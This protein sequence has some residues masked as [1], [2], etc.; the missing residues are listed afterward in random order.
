LNGI[1]GGFLELESLSFW[2]DTIPL[3]KNN[4]AR[5]A[6]AAQFPRSIRRSIKRG[7]CRSVRRIIRAA[8]GES[9]AQ[10]PGNC[11][12]VSEQLA[13]S[14]SPSSDEGSRQSS[15][16]SWRDGSQLPPQSTQHPAQCPA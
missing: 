10:L 12:D 6:T 13:G 11:R 2:L 4:A 15:H 9:S 1:F 14:V 5:R 7:V 3:L 8:S 16:Q